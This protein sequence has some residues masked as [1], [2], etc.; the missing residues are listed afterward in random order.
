MLTLCFEYIENAQHFE[1]WGELDEN[2]FN[3]C[4][5]YVESNLTERERTTLTNFFKL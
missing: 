1:L 3:L 2:I 5:K 4:C